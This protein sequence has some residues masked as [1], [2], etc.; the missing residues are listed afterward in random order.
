MSNKRQDGLLKILL[1]IFFAGLVGNTIEYFFVHKNNLKRIEG[2]VSEVEV[3]KYDCRGNKYSKRKCEKTIIKLE[4]RRGS[5]E[6]A[7]Y[8]NRGASIDEIEKGD[9]VVVYIRKWYQYILTFG[10]GGD[11]YGLEKNGIIYY[12]IQRWKIS[13]KACILIFGILFLFFGGLWIIQKITM[14]Q[15]TKRRLFN[16]R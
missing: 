12:D 3:K 5:F 2:V 9:P 8:V 15:I 7:D 16:S 6:I 4:N 1:I 13:N 14:D 10:G 11:I